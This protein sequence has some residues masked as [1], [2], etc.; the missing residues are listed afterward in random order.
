MLV[1]FACG[2]ALN[3]RRRYSSSLLYALSAL[4]SRLTSTPNSVTKFQRITHLRSKGIKR[5]YPF[6]LYDSQAHQ[7]GDKY[8]LSSPANSLIV[9]CDEGDGL[10][11]YKTNSLGFRETKNENLSIPIDIILLGDSY[12]EGACVEKPYDMASVL[13]NKTGGN[14]LNLGRGGSG[15][16]LQ[17]A[18][19]QEFISYIDNTEISIPKVL[20]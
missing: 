19:L 20:I 3:H 9:Y 12:A 13:Q 1:E 16:L 10:L 6:Y 4:K 15:P 11:E 7:I 14:I 18:I 5:V 2:Y 17:L 8:W